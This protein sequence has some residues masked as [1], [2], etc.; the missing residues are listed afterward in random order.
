MKILPSWK[1][2][3]RYLLIKYKGSKEK[4]KQEIKNGFLLFVGIVN[5]ARA[6]PFFI[7]IG[8]PKFLILSIHRKYLSQARGALL[9]CESRPECVYVS[10]TLKKLKKKIENKEK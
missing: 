5:Y 10:G 7:N 9:L 4:V 2:P 6:R 1:E 8:R 3:R